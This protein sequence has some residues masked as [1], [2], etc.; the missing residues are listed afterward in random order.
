MSTGRIICV[1]KL[2]PVSVSVSLF[3]RCPSISMDAILWRSYCATICNSVVNVEKSKT[4]SCTC[5][6]SHTRTCTEWVAES[7]NCS[8]WIAMQCNAYIR[9]SFTRLDWSSN[10]IQ[11]EIRCEKNWHQTTYDQSLQ[12]FFRSFYKNDC[13][14]KLSF[15]KLTNK[16]YTYKY[17][18]AHFWRV[19]LLVVVIFQYFLIWASV[20]SEQFLPSRKWW[21]TCF[22]FQWVHRAHA[23]T[24]RFKYPY[25]AFTHQLKIALRIKVRS[26]LV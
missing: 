13:I 12:F 1:I 15:A 5:I 14:A 24:I 17:A 18:Q 23:H 8:Q 26:L 25:L 3:R 10:E 22:D 2:K 6:H 21:K 9:P 19:R 7:C 20:L 16:N 4:F 11:S